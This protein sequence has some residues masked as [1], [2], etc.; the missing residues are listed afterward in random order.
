VGIQ[1]EENI[2]ACDNASKLKIK[3]EDAKPSSQCEHMI[4]KISSSPTPYQT[5][6][7]IHVMW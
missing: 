3:Y 2:A 1:F 4:K 6:S 5:N 7:P